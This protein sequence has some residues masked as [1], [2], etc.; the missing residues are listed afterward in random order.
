MKLLLHDLHVICDVAAAVLTVLASPVHI[1]DLAVLE[2][3]VAL[4]PGSGTPDGEGR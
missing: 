1:D 3:P 2:H 4:D